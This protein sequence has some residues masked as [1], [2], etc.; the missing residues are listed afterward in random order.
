MLILFSLVFIPVI[1]FSQEGEVSEGELKVTKAA[2]CKGIV[3]REPVDSDTVFP[4][5]T[6]K[7]FCFTKIEGATDPTK[8]SHVWK[9]G[10]K[11]MARVELKVESSSWRTWSSKRVLPFWTGQWTVEIQNEAG[12]TLKILEFEIQ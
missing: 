6:E 5:D 11:E 12:K 10:D 3:D 8:I 4:S 9:Y 1:L 2:I 7:V